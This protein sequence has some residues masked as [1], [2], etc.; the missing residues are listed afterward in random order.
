MKEGWVSPDLPVLNAT[1]ALLEERPVVE[2]SAIAER[3]GQDRVEV[4]RALNALGIGGTLTRRQ[5]ATP[6]PAAIAFSPAV[7]LGGKTRKVAPVIP[8]A[9]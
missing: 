2:A 6:S 9:S 8:A 4:I 5:P 3:A 1:V 7:S